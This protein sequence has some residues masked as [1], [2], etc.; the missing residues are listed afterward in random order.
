MKR[1]ALVLAESAL[2]GMAG[3]LV[4]LA[5]GTGLAALALQLLA[6]DMGGGY[7]PGVTPT[8]HFSPLAAAVY[9]TL[10][11][12]AALAGG[13]LPARAAQRI[14]PAL[15][16]KGLGSTTNPRGVRSG[17]VG[18]GPAL[19]LVGGLLA[20][21]PPIAGMPLAAYVSVALLLLAASSACRRVWARC[22]G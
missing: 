11:V 1:L 12:I 5:L 20:L 4:G 10:G 9:G 3:S 16:L 19:L 2:L 13:W 21:A 6:G 22:C 14:A 17:H 18:W 15:A 7:F 8:L